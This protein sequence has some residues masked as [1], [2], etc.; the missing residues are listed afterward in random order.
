MCHLRSR[1]LIAEFVFVSFLFLSLWLCH[2]FTRL[3]KPAALNTQGDIL[4]VNVTKPSV[5]PP[6]HMGLLSHMIPDHHLSCSRDASTRGLT[7]CG[8]SQQCHL[9]RRSSRFRCACSL[10]VCVGSLCFFSLRP[11]LMRNFQLS[12]GE[13]V[14]GR[15]F[16]FYC[17]PVI[18]SRLVQSAAG[19]ACRWRGW[20]NLLKK[21]CKWD[22]TW[23]V[24]LIRHHL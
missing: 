9:S 24:G 14:C 8:S 20:M 4:A 7:R 5:N 22:V 12:A 23:K 19:A 16:V 3:I 11:E 17:G 21:R 15:L 10:C 1:M 13:R 2:I 6:D 18:K